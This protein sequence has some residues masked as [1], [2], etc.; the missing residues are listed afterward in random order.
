MAGQALVWQ[1]SLSSHLSWGPQEGWSETDALPGSLA[2]VQQRSLPLGDMVGASCPKTG[3]GE[4]GHPV[5]PE[6]HHPYFP[7]PA[8]LYTPVR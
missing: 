3:P 7:A 2:S 8:V 4:P 1:G 6:S 5:E